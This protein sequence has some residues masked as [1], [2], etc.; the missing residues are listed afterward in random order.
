LKQWPLPPSP[1]SN[2]DV[3]RPPEIREH[4]AAA[5]VRKTLASQPD[6]GASPAVIE[7]GDVG[8]LHAVAYAWREIVLGFEK[9]GTDPDG[10]VADD[11][12][13][14][15]YRRGIPGTLLGPADG[16]AIVAHA[17]RTGTP[18]IGYAPAPMQRHLPA[19]LMRVATPVRIA[20]LDG[21]GLAA[22][23]AA[24][25]GTA[26]ATTPSDELAR[27]VAVDDLELALR[28]DPDPDAYV[29]RLLTLIR[30]KRAVVSASVPLDRLHG[31]DD[32]VRWGMD[33]ARDLADYRSGSLPWSDVDKG[34]LLTGPAGVGKT[35]WAASVANWCG[36]PLIVGGLAKWQASRDG[37]LGHCLAAMRADFALARES[38][39]CLMF[40]DEVDG[41]GD[42][43][44]S[45][46]AHRDYHVQIVNSFLEQ[47][48]GLGGREG[49]VVIAACNDASRLDPAIVR[50]GRLD[51]T[52]DVGLPDAC[53]LEGIFR[54]HLGIDLRG[55]DLA[56]VASAAVGSTGADVQ[57]WVRDARRAARR[58]R[59][60]MVAADLKLAVVGVNRREPATMRRIA[61]HEAGH[62][63]IACLD[64]PGSVRSVTVRQFGKYGG[65]LMSDGLGSSITRGQ[66]RVS[67]RLLLAGRAAEQVLM[68]DV[69]AGAGGCADSD[70][71]LA[72]KLAVDA[73]GSWGMGDELTWSACPKPQDIGAALAM[74]PAFARQVSALLAEV[75][76]EVV[77]AIG[78][79]RNAVEGIAAR[80]MAVESM[81][82]AE[83]EHVLSCE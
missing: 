79:H 17:L 70:L 40:V 16:N 58:N 21:A 77:A 55:A 3:P 75:H 43:A 69:S 14:F 7:V 41:F 65:H 27:S 26:P 74:R 9:P 12:I 68:G 25:F 10:E 61:V 63:A 20:S 23:I 60:P 48:D 11:D 54:H 29:D 71:A 81:T 66:V 62:A 22:A 83:I 35:T 38:A 78:I 64:R 5:M 13:W 37:H 47:L 57:R 15:E 1:T 52:I 42:R 33:L 19:D 6:A 46:S 59:R 34:C 56:E 50:S 53:A 31:M 30:G 67:L 45:S 28:P 18:V 32:A 49:V 39:P 73:L 36:T 44:R 4:A 82:G 76:E 72:T 51:R 2:V 8:W 80:L 24:C